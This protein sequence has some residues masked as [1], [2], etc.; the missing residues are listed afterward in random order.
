MLS[1]IKGIRARE[2]DL[3]RKWSGVADRI[4]VNDSQ[5][6]F[7]NAEREQAF[8]RAQFPTEQEMRRYTEYREEW[9]RRAKESDPGDA[10]LAVTCEL[11]SMCDLGCAMCYTAT[12]EFQDTVVGDQRMMPW[13]V[14]TAVI[15]ECAD[16]GVPSMLFS[17]RGE[18]TL[19][20]VRGGGRTYRFADA[21]GYA[22]SRG[23]LE[24]T[25]LTHGQT[26]DEDMAEAIVDAEPSWISV[27]IDGRGAVYNK[28]RTPPRKRGTDYDAFETVMSNIERLAAVRNARGKTRPQ[29]RTNTIFPAIA[30]DP[31]AYHALMESIGVGWVT[32]NELLDFRGEDLPE[33]AILKDWAC[34][35]PFQR[36]TVGAN[37]TILPCTG[38]HNEE[39]ALVLGAYPGSAGKRAR[40]GNGSPAEPPAPEMTLREAW[41]CSKLEHIRS[42]HRA[43]RRTEIRPGC[44]NC[45][46]GAVKH[47]VSWIPED[48]NPDT[49][50]WNN[51]AWRE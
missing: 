46:H 27:S 42:M 18:S 33:D 45:R 50:E 13:E 23:I 41:T 21:L 34:Q 19:Y 14:L 15:D 5:Y 7:D 51:R 28:I 48:W 31:A 44:R 25:S 47:G 20:R 40:N 39:A 6:S 12:G 11:T 30:D 36:L 8:I 35:Y 38:A 17:W 3:K 1:N 32:V 26:I 10:P 24:I 4:P 16:M 9:Y 43:N 22:R 49:M 2:E 37:G 29:I